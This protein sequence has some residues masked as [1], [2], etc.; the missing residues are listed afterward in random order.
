MALD[1]VAA[2]GALE[3]QGPLEVHA[4]AAREGAQRGALER[5]RSHVED[6]AVTIEVAY[7]NR[8]DLSRQAVNIRFR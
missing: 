6:E 8:K 1:E 2:E 5:L 3:A 7:I 4:V